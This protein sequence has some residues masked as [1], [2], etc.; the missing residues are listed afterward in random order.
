M[1]TSSQE[2]VI[3][4]TV[5]AL[6]R[7]GLG[8]ARITE[9]TAQQ[10]GRSL[11]ATPQPN[12]AKIVDGKEDPSSPIDSDDDSGKDD[13]HVPDGTGGYFLKRKKPTYTLYDNSSANQSLETATPLIKVDLPPPFFFTTTFTE[14][15]GAR[16]QATM[17]KMDGPEPNAWYSASRNLVG[18]DGVTYK[19]N[20]KMFVD[21]VTLVRSDGVVVAQFNRRKYSDKRG[22]VGTLGTKIPVPESLLQLILCACIRKA[23][24]DHARRIAFYS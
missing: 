13:D 17:Y 10:I 4:P 19:W 23:R 11:P 7:V 12:D 6:E 9:R 14:V 22:V 5:F 18:F 16:R 20:N 15:G 21:D 8:S 2:K 1:S 24:E 3:S